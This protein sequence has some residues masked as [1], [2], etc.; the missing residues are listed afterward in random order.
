MECAVPHLARGAGRR[1]HSERFRAVQKYLET[2]GNTPFPS[3]SKPLRVQLSCP[4]VF[5]RLSCA[6]PQNL[7]RHAVLHAIEVNA[8]QIIFVSIDFYGETRF[9]MLVFWI[10]S[11]LLER[12]MLVIQGSIVILILLL[13]LYRIYIAPTVCT[14]FYNMSIYSVYTIL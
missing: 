14:A 9:D 13:L 3:V 2:L 6:P 10:T 12:I 7:W 11:I 1:G 8:E 5:P 4:R